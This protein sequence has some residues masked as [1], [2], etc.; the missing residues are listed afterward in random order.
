MNLF[1]EFAQEY[2]NYLVGN[3]FNLDYNK[4]KNLNIGISTGQ[5][6]IIEQNGI[7]FY[8]LHGFNKRTAYFKINGILISNA[9][10]STDTGSE[11]VSSNIIVNKDDVIEYKTEYF[12]TVENRESFVRFVPFR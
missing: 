6:Y 1:Y 5:K 7:I 3:L 8:Q 10:H 9:Y 12:P 2:S 4:I 11:A